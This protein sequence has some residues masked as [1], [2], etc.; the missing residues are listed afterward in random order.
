MKSPIRRLTLGLLVATSMGGVGC[1]TYQL[2]Q[3]LPSPGI[4]RDD[5]QYFPKGVDFPLSNE[6]NAQQ[7][8][9]ADRGASR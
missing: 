6:L 3:T 4:L 7:Q 1:Q 8:A 9:E 2:G 5:Q